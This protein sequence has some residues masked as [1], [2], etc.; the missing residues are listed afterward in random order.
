MLAVG[1]LWGKKGVRSID[2]PKPDIKEPD[3][4]LVRVKEAGL[5]GTDFNTVRYNQ[6]IVGSVNSNRRHFERALEDMRDLNSRFSGMLE[7]MITHRFKLEDYEKAFALADP[8]HI[9]TV[10]E[11]EPW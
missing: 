5:D 6:V 2:I 4:V 3:E 9:K 7:K 8:S 1:M 10:M 11:V